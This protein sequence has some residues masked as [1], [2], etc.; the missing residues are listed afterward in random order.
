MAQLQSEKV[1][2]WLSSAGVECRAHQ[3]FEVICWS[4]NFYAGNFAG[5]KKPQQLKVQR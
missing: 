5:N 1:Q 4:K 3:L 2:K